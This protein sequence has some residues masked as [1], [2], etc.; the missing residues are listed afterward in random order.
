MRKTIHRFNAQPL[1][2]KQITMN[3]SFTN[4]I[5][6]NTNFPPLVEM[7]SQN[8]TQLQP[9]WTLQA[10]CSSTKTDLFATPRT[11]LKL[12]SATQSCWPLQHLQWITNLRCYGDEEW[13]AWLQNPRCIKCSKPSNSLKL[14]VLCVCTCMLCG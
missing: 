9:S 3:W 10:I 6:P 12:C 4:N 11:A 14:D 5:N 1:T 2:Q 8:L 13:I 7:Y